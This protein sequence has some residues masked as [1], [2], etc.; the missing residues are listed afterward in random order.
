[1]MQKTTTYFH[2]DF[3]CKKLLLSLRYAKKILEVVFLTTNPNEFA[4]G[5]FYKS[6]IIGLLMINFE[7]F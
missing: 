7:L 1:M 3:L 5:N 2:Y 4:I 6:Q